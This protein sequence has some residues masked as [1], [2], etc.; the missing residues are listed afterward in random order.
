MN[1]IALCFIINYEHILNKENIWREWINY[2]KDIINVY[3]FYNDKNKIK[4]TWILQHTIPPEYIHKTSYLHVIPAYFSLF[5]YA[6]HHDINNKWFCLLTDSCCPIISPTK[7]KNLFFNHIDKTIMMWKPPWWNIYFHRRANLALLPVKLRLAHEPWFVMKREHVQLI[8]QY[9]L[10]NPKVV[11]LI[12][13]G[14]FAN[15]SLF[16]IIL[17]AYNQLTTESVESSI[18]HLTDWSRMTSAT[19]PY[20]FKEATIQNVQFIEN[21]IKT[22]PFCMFIRKVAPEFPDDTI[23]KFLYLD[24]EDNHKSTQIIKHNM[25]GFAA[26]NFFIL[27]FIFYYYH[28]YFKNIS[29]K[30]T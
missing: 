2:N 19:S 20:V 29:T 3:F 11:K 10:I 30:S 5:K 7:F 12:C 26:L 16:A 21:A 22:N 27:F 9:F 15:E 8:I 6:L 25:S 28:I 23:N 24:Q 1:K 18:T 14:G 13:D 17:M 4:S